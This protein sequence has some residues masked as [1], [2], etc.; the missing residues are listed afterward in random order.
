[1]S[2]TPSAANQ[3]IVLE[4][5]KIV[6]VVKNDYQV[7]VNRAGF[8]GIQ[9]PA[10]PQG[11]AGNNTANRFSD[12]EDVLLVNLAN[13]NIIKWN[14]ALQVFLNQESVDGGSF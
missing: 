5:L 14:S 2:V 12:L 4:D 11:P 1:M 13:D 8:Q 3:V 7:I 9:G 6:K 10:G